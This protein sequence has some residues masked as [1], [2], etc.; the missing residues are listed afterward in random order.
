M[1]RPLG[2]QVFESTLLRALHFTTGCKVY[3]S[4]ML[5]NERKVDVEIRA[6]NGTRLALPVQVQ[7]T[8]RIDHYTKLRKYLKTRESGDEVINLYVEVE[9]DATFKIDEI[10]SELVRAAVT[11]QAMPTHGRWR[12]F[13]LRIGQDVAF[14]DPFSKLHAL[15]IVRESPERQQ[16]LRRGSAHEFQHD[17]FT[18]SGED[19]GVYDAHFIDVDKGAFRQQLRAS[20]GAQDAAFPVWFLPAG[21]FARDIRPREENPAQD[22]PVPPT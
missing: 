10:A 7:L 3:T 6:V 9:A 14:F 18:V 22:T 13:G 21:N 4:P 15:Y 16:A 8:T 20:I 5:D 19:G 12:V 1:K 11:V 17:R 2:G